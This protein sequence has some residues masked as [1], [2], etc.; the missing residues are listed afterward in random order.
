MTD[1]DAVLAAVVAG[2]VPRAYKANEV[3]KSPQTPYT[4]VSVTRDL[5]GH[6][7]LTGSAGTWDRRA[8]FQSF[9]TDPDGALDFDRLAVNALDGRIVSGID[10]MW[11]TQVGSVLVRDPDNKG[12]VG[13]TSTLL[14]TAAP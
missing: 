5:P 14:C 12:V 11:T 6:R 7:D 4:V 13:V 3:P 2:G 10:G 1:L 9:D 8:T